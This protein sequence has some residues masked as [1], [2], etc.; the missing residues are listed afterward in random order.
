MYWKNKII[1]FLVFASLYMNIE[2]FVRAFNGE[3]IGFKG[4]KW[5]SAIGFTSIYMGILAGCLSLIIAFLCDNPKY[6]KLKAYQKTLLGGLIITLGE[7]SAGIILNLWLH[8]NIWSYANDKFNF[9]GQIELKNSILWTFVITPLVIW[10]DSN[11]TF[12]LYNEDK[13]MNLL[14]FYKDLFEL[15]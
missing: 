7:L 15:R 4:I 13:P 6:F 9:L 8:L 1:H 11:L 2:V 5:W 14:D 3:M 10:L 12:Y